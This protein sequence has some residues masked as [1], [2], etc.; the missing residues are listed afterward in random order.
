MPGPQ[1]PRCAP[2]PRCLCGAPGPH[3]TRGAWSTYPVLRACS[4]LPCP[5]H[6]ARVVVCDGGAALAGPRVPRAVHRKA[7]GCGG[8]APAA[9]RV[10][11][12]PRAARLCVRRAVKQLS[13]PSHR[14]GV[15]C[16]LNCP[17]VL[18]YWWCKGEKV[19]QRAAG[20]SSWRSSWQT[21]CLLQGNMSFTRSSHVV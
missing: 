8:A 10:A 14:Y 6:E 11:R 16:L 7:C 12:R 2:G 1:R 9:G 4:M 5:H 13:T 21:S 20:R 18:N 17:S 3:C 19:W 15:Q